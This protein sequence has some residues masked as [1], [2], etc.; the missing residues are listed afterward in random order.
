MLEDLK[1][2]VVAEGTT[3]E[4]NYKKFL[5]GRRRGSLISWGY[6]KLYHD[7]S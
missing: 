1:A 3:E 2:E 5:G 4:A 6:N 7:I